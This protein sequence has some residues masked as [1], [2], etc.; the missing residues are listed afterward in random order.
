MEYRGAMKR[1]Q[2]A[3]AAAFI[4]L[5]VFLLYRYF[6]G[7]LTCYVMDQLNILILLGGLCFG[8]MAVAVLRKRPDK[9]NASIR[10]GSLVIAAIALL[11]LFIT[12]RP[13]CGVDSKKSAVESG[14]PASQ[15]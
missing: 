1:R 12:P 5:A 7:P 9:P 11:G 15:H 13:L 2:I 14:A 10:Y 8:V 6:H 4:L 3:D